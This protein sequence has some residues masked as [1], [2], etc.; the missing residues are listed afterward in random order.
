MD[1][2]ALQLADGGI[3]TE[4]EQLTDLGDDRVFLAIVLTARG[5]G[6]GV[7]FEMPNW[8]VIGSQRA[9]SQGVISSGLGTRA[10]KPRGL[11]GVV[12]APHR[13]ARSPW[14]QS[15]HP[16]I[17]ENIGTGFGWLAGTCG[18][19]LVRTLPSTCSGAIVV[20]SVLGLGDS[21]VVGPSGVVSV[22]GG[23]IGQSVL[24]QALAREDR[25]R[26]ADIGPS[27]GCSRRDGRG[28]AWPSHRN[29]ASVRWTGRGA[30]HLKA[31][32]IPEAGGTLKWCRRRRRPPL[33][34]KK[35]EPDSLG[36]CSTRGSRALAREAS[37]PVRG[38]LR[39]HHRRVRRGRSWPIFGIVL[40][41]IA[42]QF[43]RRAMP[44]AD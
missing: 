1:P 16:R 29:C 37:G 21:L 13:S 10:S 8:K 7:P 36:P 39:A 2:A 40:A 25:N 43:A 9:W 11:L 38:D 32:L 31:A 41:P 28:G 12:Q 6:S 18:G 23:L 35:K 44:E 5:R 20:A 24:H 14:Q 15:A 4:I 33:G 26:E 19:V 42:I 3:H 17:V 34:V 27:H 30:P 22:F